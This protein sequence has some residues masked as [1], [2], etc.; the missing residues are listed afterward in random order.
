[1]GRIA[2]AKRVEARHLGAT[3]PRSSLS[4]PTLKRKLDG[5]VVPR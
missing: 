1:V 2:K 5:S 4:H 3:K